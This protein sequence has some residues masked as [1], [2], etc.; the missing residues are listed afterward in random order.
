MT[1][2]RF[3]AVP[4][5]V[6]VLGSPSRAEV[7]DKIVGEAWV[8]EHGPVLLFGL[9]YMQSALLLSL[10][11][12]FALSGRTGLGYFI[13]TLLLGL[14]A[15]NAV[16]LRSGDPVI[17][18]A[19]TEGCRHESATWFLVSEAICFALMYHLISSTARRRKGHG[20]ASK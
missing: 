19:L 11:L 16:D 6:A 20:I 10:L 12:L 7:C 9:G 4:S 2:R 5:L 14:A 13:A 3:I 18:S 15:I 17:R 1:L 8:P